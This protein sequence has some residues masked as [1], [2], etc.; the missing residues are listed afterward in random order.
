MET[1]G[2]LF[3]E[4]GAARVAP[5]SEPDTAPP[6]DPHIH[7]EDV[8]RVTGQNAQVLERLRQG[9]ATNVELSGISLR[10]SAR[11]F[12]LREAG[13]LITGQRLA[14]GIHLYTLTE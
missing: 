5:V 8:P 14:G 2:T 6:V 10:Y 12:D 3:D 13:Y 9:P 11:M 4:T 7:P 1:Q